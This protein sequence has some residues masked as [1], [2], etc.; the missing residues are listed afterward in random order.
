MAQ[1]KTLRIEILE[2]GQPSEPGI[3][4]KTRDSKPE[5]KQTIGISLCPYLKQRLQDLQRI[6]TRLGG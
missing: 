2:S 5:Q 3:E 1:V 4:L 6:G